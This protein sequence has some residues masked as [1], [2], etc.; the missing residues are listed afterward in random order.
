SGAA[1][2]PN[3]HEANLARCHARTSIDGITVHGIKASQPVTSCWSSPYGLA[4]TT[5]A[6]SAVPGIASQASCCSKGCVTTHAGSVA[7]SSHAGRAS[8]VGCQCRRAL[9][10]G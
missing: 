1:L 3:L 6:T 2:V 7:G 10:G 9:L 8:A 5:R 4:T